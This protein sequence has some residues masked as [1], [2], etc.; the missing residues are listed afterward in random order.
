[1]KVGFGFRDITPEPG[2]TLSGFAARCDRPSQGIDDPL[3]VRALAVEE[4]GGM[5]LLL[6][7]DLLALG[8]EIDAVLHE[9]LDGG[10]AA[11]VPRGRRVFCCTHTH[12][13]PATITLLGAGVVEHSYWSRVVEQAASAA[14]EALAAMRPAAMRWST[15]TIRDGNYNRRKVLADRRV[16]M[17]QH[18]SDT[19]VKSGPVWERMLLVRFDDER[20][21]PIAGIA[22]WATHPCTVC[23]QNISADYPGELRER[24]SAQFGMPFLYLQG[25]CAN[26]NPPF[27]EMNRAEMLRNM[28][29]IMPFLKDVSWGPPAPARPFGFADDVVPLRY[30]PILSTGEARTLHDGMRAIAG[31][32]QAP[33]ETLAMMANILNVPSVD[34]MAS[35]LRRHFAAAMRDWSE[36]LLP[37]QR[38]RLAGV[39]PI[40]LK[41]W[42]VGPLVWSFVAAETFVETALGLAQAFPGLTTALVGYA[43]PVVG[44]LPTDEALR[45]GGYE[46]ASAYRFYGH[47]AP[48]SAGSEP[49]VLETLKTQVGRLK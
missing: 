15:A 35:D 47:P 44:Y 42:R 1:M 43:S 38:E 32:G 18:P 40:A 23:T 24:L 30:A 10:P 31:G 2:I 7:F 9:R 29:A 20:D 28:D 13:A 26:L 25:A 8:P 17:A 27:R 33:A 45:E 21:R 19:V 37:P 36:R 16:V 14:V 3:S 11:A 46:A 12:S 5:A 4:S 39:C 48:F 34:A 41:T 49:A 6:A 22:H